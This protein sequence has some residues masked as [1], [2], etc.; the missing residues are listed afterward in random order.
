MAVFP[1]FW[2]DRLVFFAQKKVGKILGRKGKWIS[3]I[4]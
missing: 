2:G 4:F 3:P 1:E